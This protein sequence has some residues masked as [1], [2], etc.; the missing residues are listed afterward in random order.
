MP[1]NCRGILTDLL[2]KKF[3]QHEH[4]AKE[5]NDALII[6]KCKDKRDVLLSTKHSDE[7]V[8]MQKRGNIITKPNIIVDYNEG[9]SYVDVSY[10]MTSYCTSL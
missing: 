5:S 2:A 7:T 1:S 3:Q 6:L 4:I 8:V 10:E 9:N